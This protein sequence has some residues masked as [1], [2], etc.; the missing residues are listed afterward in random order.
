MNMPNY[1]KM[2]PLMVITAVSL[3][4]F[5]L[6]GIATMTG[7]INPAR[8]NSAESFQVAMPVSDTEAKALEDKSAPNKGT[9]SDEAKRESSSNARTTAA[10]PPLRHHASAQS[11]TGRSVNKPIGLTA[12]NAAKPCTVC[13]KVASIQLVKQ[14]GDATGLGAVAGG[15]AGGL[16][17]NQVGKGKGNILMT[18]LGAGSGAYAGHTIEKKVKATESYLVKVRMNDGSTRSVTMSEKPDFAVG[19]PVKVINGGVTVVS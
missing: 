1:R 7:M 4:T 3:T 19:D 16:I 14:D 11:S 12:D 10:E 9:T 2:H 8:S 17:G 18:I 15:V 13:G 5:S 6:L